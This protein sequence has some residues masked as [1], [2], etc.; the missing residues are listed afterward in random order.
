M[1]VHS[2]ELDL[3]MCPLLSNWY[4]LRPWPKARNILTQHITTL[5]GIPWCTPFVNL[6]QY[7]A[8]CWLLLPRPITTCPNM[9]Q[10]CCI[11]M[12]CSNVAIVW[13]YFREL[14]KSSRWGNEVLLLLLVNN[15]LFYTVQMQE[16]VNESILQYRCYYTLRDLVFLTK[17][18]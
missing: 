16:Y 1:F 2:A 7:V 13:P 11:D 18:N 14:L 9:I 6:L 17:K 10:Q 12:L 4:L 15:S 8:T 5:L 3:Y